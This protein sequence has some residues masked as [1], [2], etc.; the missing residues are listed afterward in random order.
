MTPAKNPPARSAPWLSL[1][2]RPFFL[3]AGIWAALAIALWI[4]ML[5][6]GWA[7]PSRFT[8]LAW[9]V[10]EML[11]GFVMAAVAGFLLTAIPNWTQR[12]PVHGASL[13][14]LAALWLVGRIDTLLSS[15][16]PLE[17]AAG[18]ELA[19]PAALALVVARELVAARNRR[20]LPMIAPLLV[21]GCADL[22]MWLDP[23]GTRG[24]Q[25]Y[26]WRLGLAA[27]LILVS[28]IGARIVPNFT[29][30]WLVQRGQAPLPAPHGLLDRVALAGLH[31]GLV[32]WV[33]FPTHA[34][35]GVLLLAAAALT[36]VRLARWRGLATFAEPLLFVLHLGYAW[37]AAG[38][39]LLGVASL[40][41]AFPLSAAIHALTAGTM[42]TM[43]LA[44][45][46]RV[47]RGHTGRALTADRWTVTTF[48]LVN[49]AAALRI[50][51]T[52][53]AGWTWTLLVLSATL[54]IA[55]FGVFAWRYAPILL[56]PAATR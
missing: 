1:A 44:V 28:V 20:N 10:H 12:Q 49:A 34:A 52:L 56:R 33:L 27:I 40:A 23:A 36:F 18:L 3:A 45:M 48:A 37:L 50:A 38:T 24:L 26:G 39:A 51:A 29:R 47:A 14:A 41:P 2:F 6:R 13:A 9:H 19:F 17:L 30:N 16:L 55:A 15:A 7:V 32:G 43:I 46:P 25:A 31:L 54:W 4:G 5:A 53:A 42:G 8:P 22:L 35:V 21:L 11:F